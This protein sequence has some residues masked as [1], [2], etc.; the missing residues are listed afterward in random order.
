M[1]KIFGL[2]VLLL[3]MVLMTTVA[4]A[5]PIIPNIESYAFYVTSNHFNG[6]DID[7]Y[8]IEKLHGLGMGAIIP[9][10]HILNVGIR[11]GSDNY[12]DKNFAIQASLFPNEDGYLY[13]LDFNRFGS[14]GSITHLGVYRDFPSDLTGISTC[15]GGG[16]AFVSISDAE[17]DIYVSMFVELQARVVFGEGFFGYAGVSY[18]Y[19]LGATTMEAGLGMNI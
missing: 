16:L 10:T 4:L 18:D 8:E 5:S 1:K 12:D 6:G 15:G 2:I 17:K 7:G 11:F 13:R 3:L 14:E 9:I 19:H